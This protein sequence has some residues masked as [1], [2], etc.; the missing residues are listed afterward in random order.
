M[1]LSV[2]AVVLGLITLVF[3]ADRFIAGAAATARHFGVPTLLIGLTV[4]GIG[5]SLPEIVISIIASVQGKAAL[6]IGNAVGSNITNIA[7]VLG[8]CAAIT[9]LT[10]N[11]ALVRRELPA[12][13]AVSILALVLALDGRYSLIDG[14]ILLAGLAA[15]LAA[16]VFVAR[17]KADP[18]AAELHTE[19][20]AQTSLHTAL[21]WLFVGLI[22]LPISSQALVW[23]ASNIAVAFGISE[24]VVGLTVVAVGTSLPELASSLVAIKKGEHDL[25]LGNIIGSNVFNILAVLAIPALLA[26]GTVPAGLLGRDLPIM[27][28]LT[29]LLYFVCWGRTPRITRGHGAVLLAAFIAYEG[30]LYLSRFQ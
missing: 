8:L 24:L 6:A 19:S 29:A 12:L 2:C 4:V 7:L 26:P 13:M 27:L 28:A 14:L 17:N 9:P 15:L 20:A 1:L 18:I 16:L 22:L 10:V 25:A 5:T 21:G 30:L 11:V 23:G 3:G